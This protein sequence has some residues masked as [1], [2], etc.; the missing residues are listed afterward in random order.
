MMWQGPVGDLLRVDE[1]TKD[2][3]L[4]IHAELAG[5]DPARDVDV[6]V[7]HGILRIAA[8]RRDEKT[9]DDKAYRRRGLRHGAFRREL[10][11]PEGATADDV[12][13]AYKDG[14]LEIRVTVPPGG[15]TRSPT[16]NEN[17]RHHRGNRGH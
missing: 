12:K 2:G 15:Q 11:L 9:V 16:C 10:V 5:V 4:V 6:T 7:E 14:I 8:E 3:T 17:P 1:Y 13:A